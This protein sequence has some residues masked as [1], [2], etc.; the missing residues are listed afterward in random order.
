MHFLLYMCPT[1]NSHTDQPSLSL[2]AFDQRVTL[3]P[4]AWLAV[5][6]A[7]T[8]VYGCTMK[9]H[10]P[11]QD[12]T[13]PHTVY[14]MR[15]HV[16]FIWGP[17]WYVNSLC[18]KH[19]QQSVLSAHACTSPKRTRSSSHTVVLMSPNYLSDEQY[20]SAVV[21]RFH[22][23]RQFTGNGQLNVCKCVLTQ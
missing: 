8:C 18:H 10:K 15:A 6:G 22:C 13:Q 3:R 14:H 20:P 12:C 16:V 23:T 2:T 17:L 21:W 4:H 19:N 5:R 7:S 9:P 1:S 11:P